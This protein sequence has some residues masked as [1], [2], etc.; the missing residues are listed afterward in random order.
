MEGQTLKMRLRQGGL[1]ETLQ[2][3]YGAAR[4]E[5]ARSRCTGAV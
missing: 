4:L 1:D 3:L 2:S 5:A